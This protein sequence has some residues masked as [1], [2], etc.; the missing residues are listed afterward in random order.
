M[1]PA[2][3]DPEAVLGLVVALGLS[4][5]VAGVGVW[6]LRQGRGRL[7][8]VDAFV[9][10]AVLVWAS[11]LGTSGLAVALS[12]DLAAA[13]A[14]SL[15]VAVAGT[16]LGGLVAAG[17]A[18]ARCTPADLGLVRG[19]WGWSALA[20]VLVP[21]FLV[22]GA[23]WVAL[24]QVLGVD[25][26]QQALLD[27]AVAGELGAGEWAALAYGALGAPLVEEVLFRGLVY[28]ALA[29]S[30]GPTRAALGSGVLFG[31][32]HI[33]EPAAVGPLVLMGIVL[34]LLRARSGSLA[35]ALVLH[36]GNNTL[37]MGLA[38][39]GLVGA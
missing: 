33:A 29:R 36:L 20:L 22:V 28:A 18:A 12:G 35:P 21:G 23:A 30:A 25:V 34:G 24:L 15:L 37:A 17:F 39:A 10:L 38:L 26:E 14:P 31:L 1:D 16:A 4:I 13:E 2:G 19:G 9:G 6:R 32:L 27:V 7:E 8:A 11:V 3:V 5:A